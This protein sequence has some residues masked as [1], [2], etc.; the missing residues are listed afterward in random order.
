MVAEA[1]GTALLLVAVVGSGIA[2]QRL[3]PGNSGLELFES[4]VATG[5][6][7]AVII[8]AVGPVSGGHLNP[9]VSLVDAAFGGLG[10]RELLA[11]IAAQLGG[12]VA[13][14]IV[15]N[16][17]FS[18]APVTISAHLRSGPGLWLGEFVATFGLVLVIFG[19]ARSGR[20]A[21]VPFAV[22]AYITGAYFFTSSASFANPAVTVARTLS[23]TFAG[24]SPR[25][26]ALF[27]VA[28]LCGGA[29]AW[30]AIR[31]LHPDAR[32]I[33]DVV[34]VPHGSSAKEASI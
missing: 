14:V 9:V 4:A 21:V 25:S 16:L 12:A 29:A 5:C 15:A 24:I 26:V 30:L 34:V 33:S 19:V 3:S 6:A 2:A 20:N 7:L 22:G 23:N 11:Y 13:G 27:V 31:F 32:Q 28:E 17:M 10:R 1:I 18:L 8:L